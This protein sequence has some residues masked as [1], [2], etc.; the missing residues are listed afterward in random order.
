MTVNAMIEQLQAIADDG[1]GDRELRLAFQPNWPLQF[2][3]DGIAVPDADSL[4]EAELDA[5]DDRPVVSATDGDDIPVYIVEG[6]HPLN[7]SPYAPGWV[8]P[9][10]R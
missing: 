1:F 10:A 4:P 6:G 9:A 7:D 8:F 3:I 5:D 2:T